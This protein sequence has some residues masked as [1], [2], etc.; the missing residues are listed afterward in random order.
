[1]D[2]NGALLVGL[3]LTG[4]SA[5]RAWEVLRP[6]RDRFATVFF[7][8]IGL[9]IRPSAPVLPVGL[10]LALVTTVTKWPPAGMRRDG[11]ARDA[12]GGYG[13]GPRSSP[14]VSSP[15]SSVWCV[16]HDRLGALVAAYVLLLAV[17]GPVINRFSGARPS[18]AARR[19]R[20]DTTRHSVTVSALCP[21]EGRG[22]LLGARATVSIG[23]QPQYELMGGRS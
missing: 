23:S 5:E 17:A 2:V 4:E 3:S 6:L 11:R 14:G 18:A 7:L 10:L 21:A 9:S 15:S 16:R 1:M 8:A 19:P 12:G 22:A 20:H 13:L